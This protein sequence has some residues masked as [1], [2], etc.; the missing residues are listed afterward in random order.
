MKTYIKLAAAAVMAAGTLAVTATS[1]A[2]YIVCNQEG[3]C[4]HTH[5]HYA[6]RAEYGLV[7][8]PDNWH[9]GA[10]EKFTWHEHTGRGYFHG[11]VWIPF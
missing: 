3:D 2:A 4:W 7:V 6:Y 1:A 11:G 8:H 5:R 9:W 10:G